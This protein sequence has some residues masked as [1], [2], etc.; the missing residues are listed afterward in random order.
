MKFKLA[1]ETSHRFD[2][3]SWQEQLRW[4]EKIGFNFTFGTWFAQPLESRTRYQ[5]IHTPSGRWLDPN[6]MLDKMGRLEFGNKQQIEIL[7]A[8][9]YFQLLGNLSLAQKAEWYESEDVY[10]YYKRLKELDKTRN[11][12]SRL[13]RSV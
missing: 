10:F 5:R 6:N 12:H 13:A 11:P 1:S 2:V 9:E 8:W 7:Q 3:G 4:F